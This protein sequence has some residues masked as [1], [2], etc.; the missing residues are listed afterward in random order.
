MVW[1]ISKAVFFSRTKERAN[2]FVKQE[3]GKKFERKTKKKKTSGLATERNE[4]VKKRP[5]WVGGCVCLH[6]LKTLPGSLWFSVWFCE[7]G[8]GFVGFSY[9]LLTVNHGSAADNGSN[10]LDELFQLGSRSWMGME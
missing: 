7:M 1:L 5:V 6:A 10:R 4:E 8:V 3:N 2:I 9:A